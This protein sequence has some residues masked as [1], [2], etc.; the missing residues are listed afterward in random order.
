M[1]NEAKLPKFFW[2]D[3]IYTTV[4]ILNWAQLRANHEK[5]SYELWFGIPTS[6][7]HLRVFGSKCYIKRDEVNLGKFDSRS[8]E[9]IF[10]GYSPNKNSSSDII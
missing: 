3:G 8:N 1:S 4:H 6:A 7:K 5:T 9:G 10:F 2:R